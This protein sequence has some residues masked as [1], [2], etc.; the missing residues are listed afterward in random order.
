MIMFLAATLLL[1]TAPCSPPPGIE[2]LWRPETRYVI[3]GEIHGTSEAPAAFAQIVCSAS[4]QG[5][6]IAAVEL[7][8]P[9]QPQLDVFIAAPDAVPS[10]AALLRA[11]ACTSANADGRTSLAILEML[12]SLRRLKANGADI[13]LLAFQPSRSPPRGFSPNYYELDMA[14]VLAEGA[15]AR[16]NA[17]MLV[18]VGNL[19]AIKT[20][21]DSFDLT[22]AVAHLPANEVVSLYVAEQGGEGWNCTEVC[23]PREILVIDSHSEGVTLQPYRG[24]RYDGVL[25]LGP[26]TASPPAAERRPQGR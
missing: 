14:A 15:M 23:G 24:G 3:I 4:Q 16:P 25:G 21:V 9:L 10:E 22:P 18:L 11:E 19:H 26:A 12:Q 7:P 8:Q 1:S 2:Q 5:P 20:R 6:V 17:R 13:T